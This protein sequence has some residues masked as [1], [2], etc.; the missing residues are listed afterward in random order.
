MSDA[1]KEHYAM[2][3]RLKLN[4]GQ[5]LED[6]ANKTGYSKTTVIT[7]A[8]REY[9]KREGVEEKEDKGHAE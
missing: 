9:A 7:I 5:L 1:R 8:L 3:L 6:V 2:S 4:I